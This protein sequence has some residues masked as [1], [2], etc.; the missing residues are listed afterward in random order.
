VNDEQEREAFWAQVAAPFVAAY[1]ER[2]RAGLED[3]R[4]IEALFLWNWKVKEYK[5]LGQQ[6]ERQP[7]DQPSLERRAQLLTEI[8]DIGGWINEKQRAYDRLLE[9]AAR[10]PGKLS[11]DQVRADAR[12]QARQG[13]P[14][15]AQHRG[16]ERQ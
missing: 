8:N 3:M 6:L 1:A 11:L 5:T 4:G 2:G 7:G 14:S 16:K 12:D 15:K 13:Q 10:A 9:N